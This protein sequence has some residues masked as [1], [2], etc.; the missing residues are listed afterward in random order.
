MLSNFRHSHIVSLLGYCE[1]EMILVYEYMPNGS[2]NNHLHKKRANQSKTSA[3]TWVQRVNICIGVA[4]SLDYLHTGTGVQSRVIHRDVKSSNVLQDNKA[5]KILDFGLSRT[6][7]AYQ[8]GTTN[9][10]TD[11]IKGTFGYMD[12]EYFSTRRVTRKSDVY[13]FGVILLEELCGRHALDFTLDEQQHILALWAKQCIKEGKDRPT[14][15]KVL[16]RIEFVLAWTLQ[17]VQSSSN[18]STME[19]P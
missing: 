2:L 12:A 9:V 10:F 13:A 1:E 7:S 5:A 6:S 16:A 17:S 18:Q 3:L 15:T 8:L 11:Q 4:R 19:D 14:M